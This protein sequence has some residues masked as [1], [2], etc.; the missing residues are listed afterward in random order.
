[1]SA[2]GYNGSRRERHRNLQR[3]Y[4][5][6]VDKQL[7]R[8]A[9]DLFADDGTLE[10][11]GQ[12]VYRR[13]VEGA[14]I[15]CPDFAGRF[16][17]RKLFNHIQ[18]QPIIDV[19]PTG[20]DRQGRWRFLSNS[21]NIRNQRPGVPAPMKTN[22]LRGH[23]LENTTLHCL[24]QFCT[25]YADGWGKSASPGARLEKSLPPDRP[26]TVAYEPYPAT[27]A[28]PSTIKNPVTQR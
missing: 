9:A 27:L 18:L 22:T 3:I 21:V 25:P 13:Q 8:E 16:D 6:Y 28:A 10:I 26:P 12:G 19:A 24:F 2:I 1:V 14:R 11:G 17:A 7:W 4:G 15:S 5:F 20:K 23:D